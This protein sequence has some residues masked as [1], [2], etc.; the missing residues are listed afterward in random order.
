M[1]QLKVIYIYKFIMQEVKSNLNRFLQER[2]NIRM[3]YVNKC[4]LLNKSF[5]LIILQR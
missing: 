1:A 4:S 2:F 3:W 5:Y